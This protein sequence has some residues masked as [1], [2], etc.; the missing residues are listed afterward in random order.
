LSQKVE[1]R[2]DWATHEAATFAVEN[3]HYS[4]RMPKSKLA[5]VGV[6]ENG[7]F[8]GVVIFGVG[9][10]GDLF[11][12]Y[13]LKPTQGCELVR[14]ALKRDH[15]TQVTRIVSIAIK[16]L[17][18]TN[19]GLRLI[20]SFA[21]PGEGHHGGIYQGGGWIYTGRSADRKFPVL[22]GR[23]THPRTLSLRVKAGKIRRDQ[24][25]YVL[26]PGK[27]RYLMTLDSE[28]QKQIESLRKPYP[29]RAT[30]KDNVASGFQSEEGGAIPTVALQ[31]TNEVSA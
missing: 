7:K 19:P 4:K 2:I 11:C 26:K 12:P 18:K 17:R 13:G 25:E 10:T 22:D 8:V 27:H 6:W 15:K 23:V 16:L 1:L 24:I 14:I 30:S 28:M 5:K 9:A 21:D 31:S 20:V 3:W 29:K